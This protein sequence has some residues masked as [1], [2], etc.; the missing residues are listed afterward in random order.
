[1]AIEWMETLEQ[2][3]REAAEEIRRLR[4]ENE[5]M[6]ERIG[7]L[8]HELSQAVIQPPVAAE[9]TAADAAWEEER[10]EVRARVERLVRQ[11]EGLILEAEAAE[12]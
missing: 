6:Q 8:E 10:A 4:A 9:A 7:T 11:L 12:G 2:R 1:M 5:Q 3:V